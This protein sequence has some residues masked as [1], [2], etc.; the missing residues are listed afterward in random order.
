MYLYVEIFYVYSY[1]LNLIYQYDQYGHN[2]WVTK[3]FY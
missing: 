2:S 1:C 3:M